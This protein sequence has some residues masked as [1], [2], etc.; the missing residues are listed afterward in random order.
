VENPTVYLAA[1]KPQRV[2][3]LLTSSSPG[4]RVEIRLPRRDGA[5]WFCSG[6]IQIP[7]PVQVSPTAQPED[8]RPGGSDGSNG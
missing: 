1:N 2:Y 7:A 8:D 3:V 6:Q 4:Q 5:G